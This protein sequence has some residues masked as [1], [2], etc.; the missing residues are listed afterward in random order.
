MRLSTFGATVNSSGLLWNLL[1]VTLAAAIALLATASG[2]AAASTGAITKC[3]P[4]AVLSGSGCMDKYE[5]SVWRIQSPNTLNRALVAKIRAGK[6]LASDL[7][8]S[9]RSSGPGAT[10]MRRAPT[11]ARTAWTTST[12]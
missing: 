3:P 9:G 10:T 2:A 8:A 1:R 12:P 7:A 5:A 11:T 4:D 6:A